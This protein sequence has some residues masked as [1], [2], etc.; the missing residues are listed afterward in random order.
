M[1]TGARTTNGKKQVQEVEADTTI[2]SLPT[3]SS[4]DAGMATCTPCVNV[5]LTYGLSVPDK[6]QQIESSIPDAND[7]GQSHQVVEMFLLTCQ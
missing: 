2:I 4:D 3:V 5:I 7:T 6:G 1:S